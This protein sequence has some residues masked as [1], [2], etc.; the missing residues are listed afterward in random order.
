MEGKR[1][2]PSWTAL[3]YKII[4]FLRSLQHASIRS[5]APVMGMGR[6][7]GL[8]GAS[9]IGTDSGLSGVAGEIIRVHRLS[10][11]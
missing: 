5:S 9:P 2:D 10:N 3:S 8:A 7:G 11:G 4:L 1:S 6:A